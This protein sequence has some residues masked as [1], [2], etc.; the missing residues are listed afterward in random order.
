M[1]LNIE[2][3]HPLVSRV[4]EFVGVAPAP[5]TEIQDPC[6]LAER[7]AVP[8]QYMLVGPNDRQRDIVISLNLA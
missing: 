1:I 7:N 8:P 3:D 5:T 4:Q 2:T 6:I